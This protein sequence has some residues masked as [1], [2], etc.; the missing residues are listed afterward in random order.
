MTEQPHGTRAT[1]QA[2]CRCRPC[3]VANA[4]YAAEQRKQHEPG[5]VDA[6]PVAAHLAEL[7]RRG[8]GVERIAMTSGVSDATIWRIVGGAPTVHRETAETLLEVPF[9]PSLGSVI[10]SVQAWRYVRLLKKDGYDVDTI[11]A[12]A[13]LP[14][15]RFGRTRARVRTVLR[16]VRFYRTHVEEPDAEE[17]DPAAA[18][19]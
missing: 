8:M 9:R 18:G 2:G 16:I 12:A 7:R 6:G 3:C 4:A 14:R 11:A 10:S 1:Y 17:D 15:L 5:Y 19:A 13:G